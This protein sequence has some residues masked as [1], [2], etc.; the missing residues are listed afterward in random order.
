VDMKLRMEKLLSMSEKDKE[1]QDRQG[2]IAWLNRWG[3]FGV[4]GSE[5]QI[6]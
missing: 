5:F 1:R 3:L 6:P 2:W 4:S